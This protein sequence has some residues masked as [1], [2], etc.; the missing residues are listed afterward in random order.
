MKEKISIPR[1]FHIN[2]NNLTANEQLGLLSVIFH[3]AHDELPDKTIL[4][5]QIEK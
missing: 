4:E 3:Y 2:V 1:A 5:I